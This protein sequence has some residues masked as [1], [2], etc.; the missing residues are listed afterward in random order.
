MNRANTTRF[1]R[2]LGTFTDDPAHFLYS[3]PRILSLIPVLI[4]TGPSRNRC[5][6][7]V[8]NNLSWRWGNSFNL[9]SFLQLQEIPRS[10][11]RLRFKLY[12]EK[13]PPMTRKKPLRFVT[14][15]NAINES[16]PWCIN[17]WLCK[18]EL[19]EAKQL[20]ICRC[21]LQSGK[22]HDFHVHPELEEVIYVIDGELEQWVEREKHVL[23]PGELAHI[24]AG[25][26]HASFNES[27]QS[28]TF[29]AILSPGSQQ[30]PFMVDVSGDEP[31]SSLRAKNA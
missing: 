18:P 4:R 23:L 31:W 9:L 2:N 20:Q 12:I 13:G 3:Y 25:I 5:Y 10:A 19:V 21:Q 1:Q 14:S 27:A 16:V 28:C 8:T 30:G 6:N 17:E 7:A 15:Q 11:S 26:V 29:L 22:G 24:P